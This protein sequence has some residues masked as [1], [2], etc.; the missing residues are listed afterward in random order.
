MF[1]AFE[2]FC[3]KPIVN[4]AKFFVDKVSIQKRISKVLI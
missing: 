2:S 4:L 1:L 3:W